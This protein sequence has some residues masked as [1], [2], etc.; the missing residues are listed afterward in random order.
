MK[1]K[2]LLKRFNV[3]IVLKDGAGTIDF[4]VQ[5]SADGKELS[6]FRRNELPGYLAV[7]EIE[8]NKLRGKSEWYSQGYLKAIGRES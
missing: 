5:E 1:V 2:L 6:V 7:D 4:D 8:I 3:H